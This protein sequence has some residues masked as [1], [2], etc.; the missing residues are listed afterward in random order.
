MQQKI[1]KTSPGNS[2]K[3]LPGEKAEKL[4]SGPSAKKGGTEVVMPSKTHASRWMEKLKREKWIN[5]KKQTSHRTHDKTGVGKSS[6]GSSMR[7]GTSTKTITTGKI[8]ETKTKGED[9]KTSASTTTSSK[10]S[11]VQKKSKKKVSRVSESLAVRF[12]GVQKISSSEVGCVSEMSTQEKLADKEFD[13]VEELD[14]DHEI[15]QQSLSAPEKLLEDKEGNRYG[16]PQLR[17]R[18]YLEACVFID[19]VA[20]AQ[21]CLLSYHRQLSKRMHLSISAYNIVMRMWAKRVC[22][23]H[24]SFYIILKKI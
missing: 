22:I 12:P 7:P 11:A 16:D 17:I 21:S 2:Q 13:E 1:Q 23:K 15:D 10:V 19:D 6:K 3:N 5:P 20:R 4:K 9:S 24:L 8:S 14:V 18:C